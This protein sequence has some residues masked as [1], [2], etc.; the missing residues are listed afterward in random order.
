MGSL[1]LPGR[2]DPRDLVE[3]RVLKDNPDQW[4]SL[5][6]VEMW[7]LLGLL[8]HP[9]NWVKWVCRVHQ[10]NRVLMG[11]LGHRE[12]PVQMDNQE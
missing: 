6:Y 3:L 11:L 10:D 5:V 4:D 8:G 12:H 7:V 9:D 2:L 1:G